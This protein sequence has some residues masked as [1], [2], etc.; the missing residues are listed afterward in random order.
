MEVEKLVEYREVRFSAASEA[1]TYFTNDRA[2]VN[3]Q[4]ANPIVCVMLQGRKIMRVDDS[5]YFEFLP[6]DSML[7]A[8]GMRLDIEFPEASLDAP[9]ECMCIEIDRLQ[10]EKIVE[11][12]NVSQHHPAG[13]Q[14]R[15]EFDW[16][17]FAVFRNAQAVQTQMN[18]LLSLYDDAQD[19]FRDALI[20]LGH[21]ELI[22][23]LLQ[24]QARDFLVE[25][26]SVVPDTGLEAVV[27][28]IRTHPE[29]RYTSA[30]LAGIACMSEASLFRHFKQR[31]GTSPARLAS[32]FRIR[33]AR[34]LLAQAP[35][36]DVAHGLGF[37][38]V[39]HFTRVFRQEVGETP[40]ELR[41]RLLS[42]APNSRGE[43][44]EPIHH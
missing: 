31:F 15:M 34:E 40:G 17:R 38:N 14:G 5:D 24:A 12:L 33:R 35:I 18:R 11:Q 29:R 32:E 1:S 10:V 6:G 13:H 22:L 39:A 20:D 7:V 3:F 23:R 21:H 9:T 41:Q 37:A 44:R 28:A 16:S 4:F 43:E 19:P 2:K 36:S 26:R 30:E 8:P 27:E 42:A 25:H